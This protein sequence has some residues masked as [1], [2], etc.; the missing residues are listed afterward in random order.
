M[1]GSP[2]LRTRRSQQSL[3]SRCT[4]G[5]SFVQRIRLSGW[6]CGELEQIA[7]K[8]RQHDRRAA[9]GEFSQY[10]DNIDFIGR[11]RGIRTPG[12]LLPKQV[13]YQAELCPDSRPCLARSWM[14]RQWGARR[15]RARPTARP[16]CRVV[17]KPLLVRLRSS[18]RCRKMSG[19]RLVRV[20]VGRRDCRRLVGRRRV[21][22]APSANSRRARDPPR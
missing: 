5:G 22:R 8:G 9:P 20:A 13:L 3:P 14:R 21:L 7:M 2:L 1:H 17:R 12:P 4:A 6:A 15:G 16:L 10:L 19:A 11:G 18:L